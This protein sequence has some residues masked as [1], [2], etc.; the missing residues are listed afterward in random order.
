MIDELHVRQESIDALRGRLKSQI[1]SIK[2]TIAK[3]LVGDTSL[4]E[5][6]RTLFREQGVT[7]VSVLTAFGMVVGF[8][9]DVL[10]PGS[11]GG[12]GGSGNP[13]GKKGGA[14]EWVKNK[15]KTIASILRKLA[16]KAAAVTTSLADLGYVALQWKRN[17]QLL[18]LMF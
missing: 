15:L 13:S 7:V 17:F 2:E 10:I 4:G 16:S 8:I 1:T 11:G 3:V 9:V 5:K 12:G 6:I 18:F 14:K